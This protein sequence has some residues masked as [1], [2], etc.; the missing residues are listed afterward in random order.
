MAT[1]PIPS[2]DPKLE[3]KWRQTL[4]E[5]HPAASALYRLLSR[6]PAPPRCQVCRAPFRGAGSIFAA[7]LGRRRSRKSPNLC[8]L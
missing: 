3:A 6:L 8:T 1:N 7:I 2:M 4:T 5:G